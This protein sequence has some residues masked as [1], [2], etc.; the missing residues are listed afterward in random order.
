[1]STTT[2]RL[3][4]E[5]KERVAKLAEQTGK[6]SHAIILDA[7]A[8]RMSEEEQRNEF[9][10]TAE[11]R[12]AEIIATGKTIPGLKCVRTWRIALLEKQRITQPPRTSILKTPLYEAI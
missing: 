11:K 9:Y 6:T 8:Q 3:P 1:M 2:I 7:I 4:Q 12:Y 10:D 5:L